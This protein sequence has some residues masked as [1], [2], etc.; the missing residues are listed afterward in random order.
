M[1][2]PLLEIRNVFQSFPGAAGGTVEILHDINL[3][4]REH[5]VVAILGPSGCGKSTLLRAIIGL[6]PPASGQILYRGQVQIGLNPSAALVFQNFALFP[7]LTVQENVEVGLPHLALS[8]VDRAA[9]VREV[10][11]AVGLTGSE[12]AYPKELSG[13]M[14]QRAGLAR[15]LAVQPELLC[16]DEPFSA[17]DVLTSET[18]RNEVI[19]LYTNQASPVNTILM[20][21]H[22]I[23]EAVFMATRLV[24]LGTHPGVVRAVL[25]NAL[26]YPRDEHSPEFLALIQQLHALITEHALP[27]EPAGGRAASAATPALQSVP[28]VSLSSAIGL[29][30][31]IENEGGLEL[32]ALA[33]R[34]DLE[35]GQLLLVVKAAELLGWVTTPGGRVEMTIEGRQFLAADITGRKQR[36]N[37]T[38][39]GL[40]IFDFIVRA[41]ET[42]ANHEVDETVVLGRL[43]QTFPREHP[44]RVLRTVVAWARYAELFKYSGTRRVFHGLRE[45]RQPSAPAAAAGK[46]S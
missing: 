33:R 13:G 26:P 20:V 10:I 18:L 30:E 22:S 40:F 16:M 31:I 35:L 28:N 34:V 6:E 14:K 1:T 3:E 41:L 23:A 43:A 29:L 45:R 11:E 17:L 27:A 25:D 38:L 24:V 37:G 46:S 2:T 9:R 15:A 7:W 12:E 4:I 19:D 36:L 42:S 39:R 5:E 32:F 21:T 44:Q 8:T